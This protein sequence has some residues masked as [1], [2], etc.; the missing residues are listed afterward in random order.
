MKKLKSRS[1][2][3]K[4]DAQLRFVLKA[5][6]HFCG[7]ALMQLDSTETALLGLQNMPFPGVV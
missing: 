4:I 7:A 3:Q 2:K 1:K 5:F 6:E